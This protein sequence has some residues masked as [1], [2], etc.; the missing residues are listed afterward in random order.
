MVKLRKEQVGEVLERLYDSEINARI[1]WFWDAGF[2]ANIGDHL[3]GWPEVP[4]PNVDLNLHS[5]SDLISL[6]A[7]QAW[8][9]YPESEFAKWYYDEYAMKCFV[10]AV[11]GGRLIM[12]SKTK[13]KGVL[14]FK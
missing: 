4:S 1:D 11:E 2:G 9:C 12:V 13:S 3:N 6:L 7:W 5:I 8:K 10:D 14:E